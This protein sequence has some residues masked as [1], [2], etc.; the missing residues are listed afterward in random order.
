MIY[1]ASG[2]LVNYFINKFKAKKIVWLGEDIACNARVDVEI[3][4]HNIYEEI[5]K[6]NTD[7]V[8]KF[9][10]KIISKSIFFKNKCF[11]RNYCLN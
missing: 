10:K 4:L 11:S 7:K 3:S 6:R 9:W 5:F 8:H 1:R 2:E